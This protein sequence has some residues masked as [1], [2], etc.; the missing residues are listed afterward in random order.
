M[1]FQPRIFTDLNT[2]SLVFSTHSERLDSLVQ[3]RHEGVVIRRGEGTAGL[4]GPDHVVGVAFFIIAPEEDDL[5][6]ASDLLVPVE[7]ELEVITVLGVFEFCQQVDGMLLVASSTS[8][9][10]SDVV[11]GGI[12][13]ANLLDWILLLHSFYL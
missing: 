6:S 8:V 5:E 13:V 10:H 4:L 9:V 12:R 2:F 7:V 3:H 11:L 1:I